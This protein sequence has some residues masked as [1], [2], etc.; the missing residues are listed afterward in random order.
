MIDLVLIDL[1]ERGREELIR[2]VR[3]EGKRA[4]HVKAASV[5]TQKCE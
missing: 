3:N 5:Q 4:E 2:E 1:G